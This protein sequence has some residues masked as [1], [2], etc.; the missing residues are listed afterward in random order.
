MSNREK[1]KP[2]ITITSNDLIA[3]EAQIA[4]QLMVMCFTVSQSTLLIMAMAQK[5]L[6]TLG[7]H[8]V[9]DVPVFAQCG[10]HTLFD[11]T[12]ACT[13]D[14]YAHFI[15][16]PQTIQFVDIVGSETGTTFHLTRR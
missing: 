13:T 10:H 15:M 1:K 6:L 9:L 16:T 2:K 11:R 12:T 3:Y 7:A 14:G 5:W 8:K 4:K